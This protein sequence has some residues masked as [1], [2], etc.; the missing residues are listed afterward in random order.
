M[1]W[2]DFGINLQVLMDAVS[3]HSVFD[4]AKLSDPSRRKRTRLTRA[5]MN[6]LV[7]RQLRISEADLDQ[8]LNID[9]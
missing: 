6:Y 4:R 2:I 3:I 8:R 9:R 5:M 7:V 1:S